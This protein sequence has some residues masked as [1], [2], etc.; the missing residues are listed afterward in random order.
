MANLTEYIGGQQYTN[1][2]G[3]SVDHLEIQVI[4]QADY[5]ALG[6]SVDLNTLYLITA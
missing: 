4:T 3:V 1:L 2:D 5:T 6:A